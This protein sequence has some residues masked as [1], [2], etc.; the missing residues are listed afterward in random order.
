[1]KQEEVDP[2]EG[3]ND[4]KEED[5][6]EEEN[7]VEEETKKKYDDTIIAKQQQDE[8][9]V[10]DTQMSSSSLPHDTCVSSCLPHHIGVTTKSM[11]LKYVF[12]ALAQN[13]N[14]MTRDDLKKILDQSTLLT[15]LCDN[16]IQVSIE[17]LQ[18]EV[19]E[20]TRDKVN[21]QEPPFFTPLVTQVE[22]LTQTIV[23]TSTKVDTSIKIDTIEKNQTI[24]E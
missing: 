1:M 8:H 21:P 18:K 2:F 5:E 15:K 19:T 14:P 4:D 24:E 10:K 23:D 20:V 22:P 12:D 9:S 3:K 13:I 11:I 7:I 17:K 16:P 6:K